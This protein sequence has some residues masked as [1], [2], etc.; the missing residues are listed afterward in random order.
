MAGAEPS[1]KRAR[2]FSSLRGLLTYFRGTPEENGSAPAASP[3][4]E[5][6]VAPR[7]VLLPEMA[8]LFHADDAARVQHAADVMFAVMNGSQRF[9]VKDGVPRAAGFPID[10]TRVRRM[11]D[12]P[13]LVEIVMSFRASENAPLRGMPCVDV[14]RVVRHLEGTGATTALIEISDGANPPGLRMRLIVTVQMQ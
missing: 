6:V 13:R 9:T 1:R 5:L 2:G 10:Q 12:D 14:M 4:D 8:S 11:P 3:P 7:T